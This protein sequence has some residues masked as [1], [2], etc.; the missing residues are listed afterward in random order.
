M[1]LRCGDLKENAIRFFHF[2]YP[3]YEGGVEMRGNT[4]ECKKLKERSQKGQ[5][6]P[7]GIEPGTLRVW[8]ARDNRYTTETPDTRQSRLYEWYSFPFF[9][10]ATALRFPVLTVC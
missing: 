8:G 9:S 3:E 5:L 10:F 2:S 7:P 4:S 1:E 6:F